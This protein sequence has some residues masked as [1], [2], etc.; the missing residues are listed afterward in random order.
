LIFHDP[1]VVVSLDDPERDED[2]PTYF[3]LKYLLISFAYG[4]SESDP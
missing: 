1:K 2:N 3:K 4:L